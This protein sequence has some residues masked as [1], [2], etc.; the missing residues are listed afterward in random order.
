MNNHISPQELP[1]CVQVFLLALKSRLLQPLWH[2][3]LHPKVDHSTNHPWIMAR[4]HPRKE[5]PELF[6][7]KVNPL[8]SART[9]WQVRSHIAV[10]PVRWK[11]EGF[12]GFEPHGAKH[13]I[14][15]YH[16]KNVRYTGWTDRP[17]PV[18]CVVFVLLCLCVT[19][20]FY[21]TRIENG[22]V[23]AAGLSHTGR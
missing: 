2:C 9:R 4:G 5:G 11:I 20:H 12:F 19:P 21:R 23:T 3:Y 17:T 7:G 15:F 18:V 22:G 16:R 6:G 13:L 14:F 10:S 1:M 8:P